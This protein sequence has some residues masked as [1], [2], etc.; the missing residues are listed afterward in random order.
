MMYSVRQA[1]IASPE[2]ALVGL[3]ASNLKV[4]GDPSQKYRWYYLDNPIGQGDAFLLEF[5]NEEADHP[6]IVGCAGIG[7]RTFYHAGSPLAAALLADFAV[8]RAHR[9]V[10]PALLLQHA[11]RTYVKNKFHF[12]YGFPNA[13][14]IA[15]FL[16]LGY[17]EIGKMERYVRILRY[18]PY[19]RRY[20]RIPLVPTLGGIAMDGFTRALDSAQTRWL[21]DSL[22]LEWLHVVDV[23]FDTLW[24]DAH[25][26]YPIIAHRGADFLR[27]R[28]LDKPDERC[29][30]AALIHRGSQRLHAY[31]VLQPEGDA[32]HMADFLA[33]S[34][35]D[36]G[37][38]LH[39]LVPALR[40]RG[41]ASVSTR[42]L[43][44]GRVG[45]LLAAHGFQ[46]REALRPVVVDPAPGLPCD[47]ATLL[48][49]DNWYL[50]D[51][52]EDA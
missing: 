22:Q 39:R 5:R 16:R 38:L 31:A 18:A 11:T 25:P 47:P 51:A 3:W 10:R 17:R 33:A 12:A 24:Q 27:W 4:A 48:D 6:T 1:S 41:F 42:F 21:P 8:D 30:V 37:I 46:R 35:R 14:A 9:T 34:E 43:G 23:R 7:R 32:A 45:A 44:T 36:F 52:D 40:A 50:T 28:F 13:S 2:D 20:T 19:L 29:D 15:V 26:A 49:H